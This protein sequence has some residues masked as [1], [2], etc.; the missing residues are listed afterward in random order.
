M[1]NR[2]KELILLAGTNDTR[3]TLSA[4][5]EEVIGDW[6]EIE[7]YSLEEQFPSPFENKLIILTSYLLEED[8]KN[9]IGEGCH[10]LIA[11][12]VINYEHIDKLLAIPEGTRALYVSDYA[13][14][15][16][17]SI[18]MLQ[19]LGID[20]IDY[21]PHYP[22]CKASP[23]ITYAI[24]PGEIGLIPPFITTVIDIGTRLIDLTSMMEILSHIGLLAE[25][26][27]SISFKNIR[28]IID[29]N[30]KLARSNRDSEHLNKHFKRVL[31]GV[32]DGILAIDELGRI[33]VFNEIL[34]TVFKVTSRQAIGRLLKEVIPN[35]ELVAFILADNT[36]ES[37]C[38]TLIQNEFIVQRFMLQ[39]E[40]SIVATFKDMNQTIKME[41]TLRREL[42]KKGFVAK[43]TFQDIVGSSAAIQNT[44]LIAGKLAKTDLTVLIEGE[45]GSGK[46]LFASAIHNASFRNNGS[47]LALNCSS[48]PEDLM[49]SELFGYEEGAFTGAKKGGKTGVFEQANGGTIFLDEIGDISLKLQ[50]RLLR[51]LQEKEIMRIG[52][53]KIIP[54]D[55]RV[56][57]ATNKDLLKMIELGKFRED[58]YH[59]LKVLYLHLPELRKRKEDI[60]ELIQHII[61]L[62][63][64]NNVKILPEVMI[65][66]SQYE[67]YGNVREL[68]N[69]IDYMLAVCDNYTVTLNDIPDT[70]FFQRASSSGVKGDLMYRIE[71]SIA[72]TAEAPMKKPAG[73]VVDDKDLLMILQTIYSFNQSGESIGR[74][75]IAEQTRWWNK[76]LTEQQ[77]RHRIE[78]LEQHGYILIYRGRSGIKVT[79]T[80][81][82]WMNSLTAE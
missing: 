80:G 23:D 22:G 69:T 75:K 71:S 3:K 78:L 81:L 20:H 68:K 61:H 26:G 1:S 19:Q 55:V 15:C 53:S 41:R 18:S 42:V 5:L 29:L 44:K 43:Y 9:A 28:S 46:E 12:R 2:K 6:F 13:Q 73:G 40:N 82:D 47:Y 37:R 34:E 4:Q 16:Y 62:S 30:K 70:H 79:Q 24:T 27:E 8:F 66:L 57:A 67:W 60:T 52:G 45:S 21:I 10:V 31:D 77:V 51:V 48:L 76:E 33:T 54:I 32:D 35:Q 7:S 64:R 14:N 59:R 58:L 74:K 38:F 25:K 17:D 39:T 36:E 50:A 63:G 11:K 49:E 56:I 72:A 65:R